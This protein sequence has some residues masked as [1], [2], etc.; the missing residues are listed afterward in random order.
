M[1]RL[2]QISD[3]DASPAADALFTAIKGK[4]GKVPNLYRVLA[5]QPAALAATL[6]FGEELGKGTF[7][8]KTREAIALVVAGANECDYCASAHSAISQSL[9]VSSVEIESRLR[10]RSADPKTQAVLT[11]A[12]TVV[13]KRGL[14]SD[15]DLKAAGVALNE[16]EIIETIANVVANILTNYVNHIAQTEIDFPA[17]RAKAA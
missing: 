7:D 1:S 11:F 4:V 6:K 15:D 5:N 13:E 9:G 10:G 16:G 2:T 17:V 14:V 8:A 3:A 12:K